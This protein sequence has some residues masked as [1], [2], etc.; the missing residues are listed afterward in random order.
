M[1]ARAAMIPRRVP[2]EFSA[3][4]RILSAWREP[5]RP[6]EVLRI[7]STRS[8]G[9]KASTSW[10]V[11]RCAEQLLT[12]LAEGGGEQMHVLGHTGWSLE[13]EQLLETGGMMDHAVMQAGQLRQV[14][15][16]SPGIRAGRSAHR[17]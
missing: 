16:S 8:S 4:W 2:T 9:G 1:L 10:G 13:P 17:F 15:P 5:Y 3:A 11:G 6:R 12:R 7:R 14:M